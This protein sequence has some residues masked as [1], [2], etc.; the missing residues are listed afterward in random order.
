MLIGGRL[1]TSAARLVLMTGEEWLTTV[2]EPALATRTA[3]YISQYDA[4]R[5]QLRALHDCEVLTSDAVAE[6]ERR[7]DQARATGPR[8]HISPIRPAGTQAPPPSNRLLR[9]L[10]PVEPLADIGAVM[11]VLAS[12]EVWEHGV[13]LLLAGVH[14]VETDRED[15]Q[16]VED[17]E[18]WTRNRR[19][20]TGPAAVI[21][22]PVM[23]GTRLYEARISLTDDLG[24]GYRHTHGGA[25][26]TGTEWRVHHSYAPGVPESA[27][28]LVLTVSDENDRLL[29]RLEISL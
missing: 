16:F 28:R 18:A 20:G 1:A 27:R 13:E 6:A 29:R 25:S 4:L 24:T 23:P 15:R 11:L 19:G 8:Q 3:V 22:P 5:G 14:N 10:A 9:V 21:G 2:L 17:L 12:V 26:G 7:L